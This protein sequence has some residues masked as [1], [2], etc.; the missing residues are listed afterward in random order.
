MEHTVIWRKVGKFEQF[1]HNR[2]CV[3]ADDALRHACDRPSQTGAWFVHPRKKISI[4]LDLQR[5]LP[6][7]PA[8]TAPSLPPPGCVLQL[9]QEMR[10]PVCDSPHQAARYHILPVWT[11]WLRTVITE[12]GLW[13]NREEPQSE[14]SEQS[15]QPLGYATQH[16]Q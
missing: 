12:L 7:V 16:S 8:T 2:R 10:S 11:A 15:G 1:G 14:P 4:D 6:R 13:G 9:R 5:H 3:D